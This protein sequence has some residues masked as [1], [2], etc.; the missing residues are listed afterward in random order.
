MEL[1]WAMQQRDRADQER[2]ISE[3]VPAEDGCTGE[4][5][6]R[7]ENPCHLPQHY[8]DDRFSEGRAPFDLPKAKPNRRREEIAI[9]IPGLQP[10]VSSW[11]S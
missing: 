3:T 1:R 9:E 8:E 10:L 6:E 7:D 11:C 4:G 5:I 2:D